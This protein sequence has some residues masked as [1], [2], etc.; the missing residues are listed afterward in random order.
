MYG[1]YVPVRADVV[2]VREFSA[3]AD[4]DELLAWL[5]TAPTPPRTCY[6]VHGE[7]TAARALARRIDAELGW[8]VAVARHGEQ[9]LI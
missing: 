5:R 3:H 1:G 9:I 4:S 2:G 6:V 8:C 7:L